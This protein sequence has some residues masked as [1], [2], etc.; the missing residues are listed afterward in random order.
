MMTEAQ[1]EVKQEIKQEDA[2]VKKQGRLTQKTFSA[3]LSIG[4]IE[5]QRVIDEAQRRYYQHFKIEQKN[6]H[7]QDD[8]KSVL[9]EHK[10]V[11]TQPQKG[12]LEARVDVKH[13]TRLKF[14][15]PAFCRD[16]CNVLGVKARAITV[17]RGLPALEAKQEAP[18]PVELPVEQ[19][20]PIEL[21]KPIVMPINLPINGQPKD[22]IPRM[23]SPTQQKPVKPA[24]KVPAKKKLVAPQTPM[25][26]PPDQPKPE[27]K[28]EPKVAPLVEKFEAIS[29]KPVVKTYGFTR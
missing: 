10:L 26:K 18:K 17:S 24:K 22:E 1:P 25:T 28:P 29:A 15:F 4:A 2:P 20:K 8:L 19:P 3:I 5:P 13:R 6:G 27:A 12:Y 11:I 23:P 9:L 16:L 14:M 21:P 7:A